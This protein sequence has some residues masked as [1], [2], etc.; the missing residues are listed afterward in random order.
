MTS[1][2]FPHKPLRIWLLVIS[3]PILLTA[4]WTDTLDDRSEAYIEKALIGGAAIYATARGIN[5]L[6]SV[7]QGTEIDP[8]L[9]TFTVGEVL[10]RDRVLGL[11]DRA[12][13][14]RHDGEEHVFHVPGVDD[15]AR[16]RKHGLD[17]G[18][19][20]QDGGIHDVGNR[21]PRHGN[22]PC[23]PAF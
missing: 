19:G 4:A 8:P 6:V 18:A 7:L 5:A 20:K 2:Q 10:D 12:V 3:I 13:L 14:E 9:I 17:R 15:L 1:I 21:R 23:I 22:H 16:P 11:N